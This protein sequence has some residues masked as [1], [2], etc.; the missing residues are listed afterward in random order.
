VQN[1]TFIQTALVSFS[2]I[3]FSGAYPLFVAISEK[4]EGIFT[5]IRAKKPSDYKFRDG[6]FHFINELFIIQIVRLMKHCL[7]HLFF[8]SVSKAL[9]EKPCCDSLLEYA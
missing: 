6:Y 7:W 4:T 8:C 3:S 1:Y 9:R 2:F 5:T